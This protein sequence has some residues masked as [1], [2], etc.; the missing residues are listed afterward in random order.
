MIRQRAT[1]RD[2]QSQHLHE[3]RLFH[4]RGS[5]LVQL[6]ISG[7]VVN[8][9]TSAA[10]A[11]ADPLEAL[12]QSMV[13]AVE[14]AEPFVVSIARVPRSGAAA[15]GP[16]DIGFR[17]D[18]NN[19]RNAD[20]V[21]NDFGAGIIIATKNPK[22]R[23]VILTNYHVVKGGAVSG[24]LNGKHKFQI[25]AWIQDAPV[26]Q[27]TII[28]ADPHSDL[29]VLAI[30][31]RI[32]NSM[33]LKGMKIQPAKN[34]KK[35]RIVYAFGNPYT[36][37]RDGSASVGM[38]II[39]NIAR[40]KPP[41]EGG[42]VINRRNTL[43]H[44]GTLLQISTRLELGTS[45]GALLDRTGTLIGI[46]TAMAAVNGY[47]QSA[48]YAIPFSPAITRVI[49]Q[50][51]MGY[52]VEYGFLGVQ[53]A[54]ASEP[55]LRGLPS[56][57]ANKGAGAVLGVLT[58]SAAE[59]A[60]LRR[61][62]VILNVNGVTVRHQFDMMREVAMNGPWDAASKNV[63]RMRIWRS[64]D[65]SFQTVDVKPGKW[66]VK[67]TGITTASRFPKW[68]GITVD[69]N[70]ARYK[71][72]QTTGVG[73]LHL[74]VLV[75]RVDDNVDHEIQQGDFISHVNDRA[76]TTPAEFH[77]AVRNARGET[78]TVTLVDGRRIQIDR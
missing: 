20:F 35:G 54:D 6:L 48:G 47:E 70:T 26:S 56:E 43:H 29:A 3:F 32:L 8:F 41:N 77:S 24:V 72:I 27:A 36:A 51:S 62:D 1:R 44:F 53:T 60:G 28:A 17:S 58:N 69:F 75:T 46:T 31:D 45:G 18:S 11:Q 59:Q 38:G 10:F 39:S 50:L 52:E 64:L 34:L 73:S 25:Y 65:R 78:V 33:S 49:D 7:A 9:I 30:D 71:Y 40:S 66:P 76:V 2:N 67:E 57:R 42:S 5:W 55:Q 16:V 19:P 23:V 4:E 68:Q 74:A 61:G 63:A 15:V 37:A 21:P 22:H 14:S 12:E 13:K